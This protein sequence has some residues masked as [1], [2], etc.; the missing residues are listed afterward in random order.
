MPGAAEPIRWALE[1][2]GLQ[3]TD[4]RVTPPEF[5]ELKQS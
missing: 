2:S 3:W 5:K 4:K 1:K